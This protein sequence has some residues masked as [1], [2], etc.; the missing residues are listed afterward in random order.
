MDSRIWRAIAD[1]N[2]YERLIGFEAGQLVD[3]YGIDPLCAEGV[4]RTVRLAERC[5]DWSR[6]ADSLY[7][8]LDRPY[9]ARPFCL[10]VAEHTPE[11]VRVVLGLDDRP[12]SITCRH[13]KNITHFKSPENES[14]HGI[15]D[16]QLARLPEL[17]ERPVALLGN[18]GHHDGFTCVLDQVNLDGFPICVPFEVDGHAV[19]DYAEGCRK[20]YHALTVVGKRCILA[21]DEMVARGALCMFDKA[22][23]AGKLYYLDGER[24]AKLL[25]YNKN[26][27]PRA[28]P[29]A[30]RGLDGY[31]SYKACL[32]AFQNRPS[33]SSAKKG[34]VR[35]G[36]NS[37]PG[38]LA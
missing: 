38:R 22:L 2:G 6:Y 34:A 1:I 26:P 25:S 4:E 16:E 11:A 10:K 7:D 36:S 31:V 18:T 33:G 24:F 8:C 14:W 23:A 19:M 3:E 27:W 29:E 20:T 17:L 32:E 13:V 28:M 37:R 21:S 12:I 5:R 30:Y 9:E 35:G 15:E